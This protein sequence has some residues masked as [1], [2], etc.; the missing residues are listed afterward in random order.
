MQVGAGEATL[1]MA[2][3]GHST[4]AAAHC[5]FAFWWPQGNRHHER[6]YYQ[7]LP[8]R[9]SVPFVTV[10]SIFGFLDIMNKFAL[11]QSIY[12]KITLAGMPPHKD[13]LLSKSHILS[14][15]K[16]KK[17][18]LCILNSSLCQALLKAP[19]EL[20][21]GRVFT[22]TLGGGHCCFLL[23]VDEATETQSCSGLV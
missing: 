5:H 6:D 4:V 22:V 11:Y 19:Q 1:A 2:E 12:Y 23:F 15:L 16:N 18:S 7:L 20:S 9:V 3:S 10:S 13:L 14:F 17:N 8:Q 21:Q